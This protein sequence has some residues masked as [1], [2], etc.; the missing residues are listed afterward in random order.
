M[1]D[2]EHV[3]RLLEGAIKWN[4]WRSENPGIRPDLSGAHLTCLNPDP[5][6]IFKVNLSGAN[7]ARANLTS[8]NLILADLVEADLSGA[9]CPFIKLDQANMKGALLSGALLISAQIA[10]ADLTG[11]NLNGADLSFADLSGTSL[12]GADVGNSKLHRTVFYKT[13]VGDAAFGEAQMSWTTLANLDLS[14]AKGLESVIHKGPSSIGIDT[15]YMSSGRVP[16]AFLRGAGVLD[17][18]IA[19]ARKLRDGAP[20]YHSCFISYS[21]VEK[22]FAHKLH[23][24]L[25]AKGIPCYLDEPQ[26]LPGQ[27]IYDE[28]ERAIRLRDKV[29]LCCSKDSLTS[30][31]VDAEISA[32]FNKEQR[33]WK[34]RGRKTLVLI[35][36]DLDGYMFS[37]EWRSGKAP[38]IR[39]RLAAD[40]REWDDRKFEEQLDRLVLALKADGEQ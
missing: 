17:D 23:D 4:G 1:P 18:F 32:A 21:H 22:T 14:G 34:Q 3:S 30:W 36:L 24:A 20:G 8:A 10:D 9:L 29:L 37:P 16:D 35:P 33:L 27:D 5:L 12:R 2:H 38:A 31:W 6:N 15:V 40:F 13:D 19:Y 28:L 11:V 7:L 39:S 26:L 25:R